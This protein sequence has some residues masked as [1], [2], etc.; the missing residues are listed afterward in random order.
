MKIRQMIFLG[1]LLT[2]VSCGSE[3]KDETEKPVV[4]VQIEEVGQTTRSGEREYV[5]V[6]EEQSVTSVSFTGSGT[7]A[8]VCVSAGQHVSKGQ[9]IAELD[10]TQ[11]KNAL[12]IAEAMMTQANDA[13]ARMKQLH[14]N[15]S[16]PDMK[17]METQSKVEQAR[18]QLEM[19]RKQLSECSIYAPVSGIVGKDVTNVGET[20]LPAMPVAKILDIKNVKV[21]VS[22]PEKEI[23]SIKSHTSTQITVDA[24]G[25]KQYEGGAI[26]KCVEASNMTHTYDIKIIVSNPAGELLPGMV[27]K[28]RKVSNN[29]AD[30]INMQF[31]VP[32]AAVHKNAKSELFVWLVKN[33]VARRQLVSVGRT[34]GNRIVITKGLASGD[35][36]VTEGHQKLSEGSKIEK[37]IRF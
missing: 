28:V 4:R 6:V 9:L 3:K 13:L 15:N 18:S 16:L 8:R 14:D 22:I 32:I 7:L 26:E 23:A 33:N 30:A 24:N 2:L 29:A 11:A 20:V 10:K 36:I 1:T 31:T 34:T 27:C 19:A 37:V 12:A 25:G 35:K 21:K 5:G 17:W